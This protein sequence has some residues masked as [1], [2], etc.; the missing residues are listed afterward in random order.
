MQRGGGPGERVGDGVEH[1]HSILNFVL[2]H[3]LLLLFKCLK[4]HF[5]W[6]GVL[7]VALQK[8]H[9]FN[10]DLV[11]DKGNLVYVLSILAQVFS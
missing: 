7:V 3:D 5:V 6:T 1:H 2:K 8:T 9:V 10:E 4:E 11:A